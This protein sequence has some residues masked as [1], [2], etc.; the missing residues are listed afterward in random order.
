METC[1]QISR[2]AT[3]ACAFAIRTID[4][5]VEVQRDTEHR[6]IVFEAQAELVTF[7]LIGVVSVI[8]FAWTAGARFA[9]T[10]LRS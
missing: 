4:L 5:I 1:A 2:C 8:D 10:N 7:V 6:N 9:R 3:E